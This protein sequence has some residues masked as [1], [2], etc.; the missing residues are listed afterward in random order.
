MS[1]AGSPPTVDLAPGGV[2]HASLLTEGP[3]SSYPCARRA[4]LAPCSGVTFSPLPAKVLMAGGLFS[5][6]LSSVL[7]LPP[8]AVVADE[9]FLTSALS[10]GTMPLEFGLSS[11]H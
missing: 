7:Q 10:R 4:A 6:A 5:V 11:R 9:L 3:V 8:T 1:R 2:F